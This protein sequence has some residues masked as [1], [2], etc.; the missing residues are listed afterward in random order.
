MTELSVSPPAKAGLLSLSLAAIGVVYGDIGTSP[1]YA[2]RE[3]M[4]AAGTADGG[5][6]ENVLGVLSLITW[7][8]MII[9]TLKYVALLMRADN[10]GEGGTLSLLA[11]AERGL[12]GRRPVILALGLIGAALF[13][14]D[15]AI[16]P[17]ISVLS[18]VEGLRLVTTAFDPWIEVISVVI[19]IGLFLVQYRGTAAVAVF[20]GPI[21][22][23]WFAVMAWGGL[24][25]IMDAPQV[26]G[27][28]NPWHALRFLL[29]NGMLGLVVL[30]A[31]F[32]AV[33]G[34]EAL[35]ADMGHFGRRPIQVA[36]IFVVLPALLV[37]YFGQGALIL[38]D[39]T[40]LENPFFRLYPEN[41]LLPVVILAT[42]ATI[43]ASQ[44]VI[45]G[46]FSLTR[47]AIQLRLLPRMRIRHTSDAQEGQIYMP[48]VN[49]G[50]MVAVLMLVLVFGSSSAL[51]SAYGI[52]VTGTMVVTATLAMIVAHKHW[53]LPAP[54]A[55]AL[56]LPFLALDVIFFGA[57]LLKLFEGG[58]LPLGLAMLVVIIMT[59]WI[60]GT[61]V[62]LGKEAQGEMGL[63]KLI[64]MLASK[65]LQ[66]VPGTAVFLT[67]DP[68]YAPAAL[69][70]SLKHFKVLH[71]QNVILTIHT[72]D[73]PRVAPED[74][75]TM[76]DLSPGFR[77]VTLTWGYAEEPDVPEGL[78]L[79][80]RLGWKFD[81]MA[82]S[83]ILSRR[84]LRLSSRR[85]IPGWMARLFILMARNSAPASDYFR[86][87]AGRVV[88]LGTQ[89]N[90]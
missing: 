4:K 37:N 71:E 17:A 13:F 75:V 22:L 67:S 78:A 74:R 83:F 6:G 55:V 54:F 12:G 49:H 64:A 21:T 30:G 15:A 2:F 69:L 66:K 87:P 72:A 48:A 11:L 24:V 3:A 40:A 90:V 33:T 89:V 41:L 46:A 44:A 80:R 27:A 43:I 65:P 23:V 68:D 5:G 39:P 51:A 47:Q 79:C 76:L 59:A 70:H 88:E 7:S 26:L 9:V 8:L 18:A 73:I 84:S 16:T 42:A 45:S 25:H 62:V 86:I 10:Q 58:W 82:T 61:G 77:Q 85:E 53:G 34:A 31:V 38:K 52:A 29:T 28:L 14:G 81:I 20:F 56:F 1:L 60:K 19:I 63:N 36:W 50:L 57:N 35:Y 32:L